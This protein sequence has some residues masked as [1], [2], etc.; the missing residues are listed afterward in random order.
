MPIGSDLIPCQQLTI[1]N[2]TILD[3][4]DRG[5]AISGVAQTHETALIYPL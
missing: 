5:Q 4:T 1:L 3:F 2:G